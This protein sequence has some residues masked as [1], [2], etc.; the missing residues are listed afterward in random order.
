[1]AGGS[2]P[3]I[4]VPAANMTRRSSYNE[5]LLQAL[6]RAADAAT[7]LRAL[8]PRVQRTD[9]ALA[10][11]EAAYRLARMRYEGGLSGYQAVLIVEDALLAAREQ[12]TSLRLRGFVLDIALAKALGGGFRAP[13]PQ[14]N[15]NTYFRIDN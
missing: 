10:R 12:S 8:G 4:G 9:A 2:A 13:A 14:A 3:T 11:Q 1:M 6:H 15:T 7:S 5:E